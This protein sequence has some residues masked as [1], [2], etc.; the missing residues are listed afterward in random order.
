MRKTNLCEWCI[1]G[2]ESHGIKIY[3]GQ[4]VDKKCDCCGD[5]ENVHECIEDDE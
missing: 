4:Y 5:T 3:V 1:R 2:D